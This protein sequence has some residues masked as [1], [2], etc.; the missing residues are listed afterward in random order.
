MSYFVRSEDDAAVKTANRSFDLRNPLLL[1]PSGSDGHPSTDFNTGAIESG[2]KEKGE[3][4]SAGND[5]K[6]K[7][8]H[9]S[10]ACDDSRSSNSD[11]SEDHAG[12]IGLLGSTSLAY[13]NLV[14]PGIVFLPATFQRSGIIPTIFTICLVS[15]LSCFSSL[16]FANVISK[17]P[18][19]H[20]FRKEIEY[21]EIFKH[22]GGNTVYLISQAVFFLGIM[23]QIIASIVDVAQVV[24]QFFDTAHAIQFGP[25][26][27]KAIT[28][29]AASCSDDELGSCYPF[30]GDGQF[31]LTG[32]YVISALCFMP[33]GL[34]DLKENML[35]QIISFI[36]TVVLILQFILAFW[37]KGLSYDNV[38]L[39]GESWGD[40]FGVI[41]FN[42]A[43]C[44]CIPAWLYEKKKDVS[45]SGV[46]IGSSFCSAVTY[47]GLGLVGALAMDNV[48]QNVL[49]PLSSG[50]F[51]AVSN[52]SA[53][54]FA[55]TVIGLGIPFFCV[56]T[57]LNLVSSGLCSNYTGLFILSILPLVLSWTM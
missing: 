36:L 4:S 39:W 53:Q 40:L 38:S 34:M 7:A 1:I 37:N 54:L 57:R 6:I 44:T 43:L 28:W 47:I 14:G 30:T 48:P 20:E 17:Y 8:V 46:V 45:V 13:N 24:D 35:W 29:N 55:F 3:G 5:L 25:G 27:P 12:F 19:N 23:C 33:L 41:L 9:D 42:N 22:F 15:T 52:I 10:D 26:P 18:G 11:V 21:S 56:V 31:V 50:Y 51:G 2:D 32:G 16:H 49:E